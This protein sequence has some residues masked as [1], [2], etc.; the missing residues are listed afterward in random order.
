M[1]DRGPAA[2]RALGTATWTIILLAALLHPTVAAD[3][4]H[5]S[6]AAEKLAIS[7]P[8]EKLTY[9]VPSRGCTFIQEYRDCARDNETPQ[10]VFYSVL[11]QECLLCYSELEPALSG[12]Y[13]WP[14]PAVK[15]ITAQDSQAV[16][17]GAKLCDSVPP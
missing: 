11:K 1:K 14:K 5:L 16:P 9:C 15:A 7:E 13:S 8:N 17:P 10:C 4:C 3:N 2:R 6:A 12:E